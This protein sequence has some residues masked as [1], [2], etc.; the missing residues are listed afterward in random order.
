MQLC[1]LLICFFFP[2][3]HDLFGGDVSSSDEEDEKDINILDSGDETLKSQDLSFKGVGD[4]SNMSDLGA[5]MNAEASECSLLLRYVWFRL[6]PS[7]I[8]VL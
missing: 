7:I 8:K 2:S 5:E 3:E 1:Y 4:E 6:H